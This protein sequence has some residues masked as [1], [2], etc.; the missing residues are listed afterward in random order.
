MPRWTST[1]IRLLKREFPQGGRNAVS[2]LL[3]RHTPGAIARRASDQ[4]IIKKR[5]LPSNLA[6]YKHAMVQVI[7]ELPHRW[8][9]GRWHRWVRI[10][11]NNCGR[12]FDA[13]IRV[14]VGRRAITSCGCFRGVQIAAANKKKGL[15]PG[16]RPLYNSYKRN[17][18]TLR[19]RSFKLTFEEFKQLVLGNCHYCGIAAHKASRGF[20]GIDRTN[21]DKGYVNANC[22]SSCWPCN[23][24]K[25]T[26]SYAAFIAWIDRVVAWRRRTRRKR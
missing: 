20:N 10:R 14:L 12:V 3:S 2:V 22:V 18:A 15:I 13:R 5:V 16:L 21:N 11:C 23:L 7:K 24:A 26:M 6:G 9:Y 8:Q 1:E 25:G 17:C 19:R 4:G